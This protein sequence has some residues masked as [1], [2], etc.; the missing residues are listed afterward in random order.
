MKNTQTK[1][2]LSVLLIVFVLCGCGKNA[3]VGP[4]A[5][6]WAYI[7]DTQ[8]AAF[9]VKNDG[10]AILDKVSYTA[11]A[12]DT[13][14]TLKDSDGNEEKL[15]YVLDKDGMLL[16]KNTTYTFSGDTPSG[17]IGTWTHDKWSFEFTEEGTFIE[18]GYFPGY[19]VVDE[20]DKSIKLIYNDHFEDTTV[21]YEMNG[22]ELLLQYPW[23]MVKMK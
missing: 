12:D 22:N 18:D 23:R 19:Y 3:N 6:E 13:Y 21:Y 11:A 5:G 10:K 1:L 7:H 20:A 8:T 4:I 15:K 16:Y 2:L 9:V 14:I 17:I